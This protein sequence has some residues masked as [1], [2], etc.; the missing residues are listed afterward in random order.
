MC[1]GQPATRAGARARGRYGS[2]QSLHL[3]RPSLLGMWA[4]GDGLSKDLRFELPSAH[5]AN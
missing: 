1:D 5:I 2:S 4:V 3:Q